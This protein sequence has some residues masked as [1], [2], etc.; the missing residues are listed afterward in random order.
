MPNP[1]VVKVLAIIKEMAPEDREQLIREL[2][3]LVNTKWFTSA[4][5]AR[6][7]SLREELDSQCIVNAVRK[8]RKGRR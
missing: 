2:A 4:A 5:N 3:N 7:E 6:L 1:A 8:V